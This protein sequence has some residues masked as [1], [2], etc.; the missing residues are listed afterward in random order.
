MQTRFS[1]RSVCVRR[2]QN[3][4]PQFKRD[5]DSRY[6]NKLFFILGIFVCLDNTQPNNLKLL[7][8]QKNISLLDRAMVEVNSFF[9]DIY[10]RTV[11][12]I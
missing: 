7:E 3:I 2:L 5:V 12:K 9:M 6:Q 8:A 10:V 11:I 4:A 1:S